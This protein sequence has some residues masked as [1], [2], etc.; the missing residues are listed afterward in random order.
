MPC[1]SW[2]P[3]SIC[4][5]TPTAAPSRRPPATT[6]SRG[7]WRS[8]R[9]RWCSAC[10][11][12]SSPR[13]PATTTGCSRT[14]RGLAPAPVPL[15]PL[16]GSGRLT[17][18]PPSHFE[19][20]ERLADFTLQLGGPDGRVPPI[21]DF[22]SGRF[23][24]LWPSFRLET[25]AESG[26]HWANLEGF[27]DLPGSARI[28]IED[29]LDQRHLVAAAAG[30][31]ARADFA[32]AGG[33]RHLE[34][35]L[36]RSLA[37]AQLPAGAAAPPANPAPP[38]GW[39]GETPAGAVSLEILLPGADL[40]DGLVLRAWPG[41]G[42][43]LFRSKRLYLLVRC[44]PVGQRGNGGHAHHDQLG[45]VVAADGRT[46][47]A[48]P[49]SY[50]YTPLPS[51]RNEYRSVRAHFAPRTADGREPGRLDRGL[52]SLLDQTQAACLFFGPEGFLGEHRG[53]GTPVRRRVEILPDRLR[54][55]DSG[56]GLALLAPALPPPGEVSAVP[57][58]PGYGW[59][60]R[61]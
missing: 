1:A 3:R 38:P 30:L 49:G 60:E 39:R 47:V 41:F 21:G 59:R 15:W 16:P 32:R 46:I 55:T 5:S 9:P 50:L 56:E 54:V 12:A 34:T 6:A 57:F 28:P 40:R 35:H 25:V 13:S 58:S 10:P 44:G 17:P 45:L 11:S 19:R 27:D 14:P 7:R 43:Y 52:F 61:R 4:S 53:Y 26:R 31:F 42:L 2:W 24:K 33:E 37:N 51:R 48:D 23:L 18:F 36:I 8:G 20:L 22:D 29:H